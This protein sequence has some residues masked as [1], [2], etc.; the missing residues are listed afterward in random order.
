MFG[1]PKLERAFNLGSDAR[2]A[3]ISKRDCPFD[4]LKQELERRAWR[5]GWLDVNNCWPRDKKPLPILGWGFVYAQLLE[6]YLGGNSNG[7]EQTKGGSIL[8]KTELQIDEGGQIYKGVP[9]HGSCQ[10]DGSQAQ[11]GLDSKDGETCSSLLCLSDQ[12]RSGCLR[13]RENREA[14]YRL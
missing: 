13:S 4:R 11:P 1:N 2:L 10:G 8:C 3:G 14:V 7:S 9:E 12:E 5:A 6:K